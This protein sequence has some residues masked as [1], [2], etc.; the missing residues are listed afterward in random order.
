[1]K[2]FKS[3][4]K[5]FTSLRSS[6]VYGILL[7]GT[8]AGVTGLYLLV[9]LLMREN[10]TDTV[11]VNW[12]DLANGGSI[13]ILIAITMLGATVAGEVSTKMQA[14]A[15]LTQHHRSSWFTARLALSYLF[16]S[17]CL[18]VS[19]AISILLVAL[20]P[21]ASFVNEE[22]HF[23]L[24]IALTVCIY[25]L[26]AACIGVITGSKVAAIAIP[27]ALLMVIETLISLVVAFN[28]EVFGFLSLLSPLNR[29]NDI[30]NHAVGNTR[31]IGFHVLEN[32]Q[33]L[34][35]DFAVLGGWAALLLV[36]AYLV[37]NKRDAK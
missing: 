15:F 31:E 32:S 36:A 22:A 14:Q 27:L 5:K 9:S 2:A 37:N 25:S 19:I 4:L 28:A 17:L 30:T 7:I 1:M 24:Q 29:I 35:F 23:M 20:F 10:A 33:P 16:L 21:H 8:I 6:Y 12:A 34:W 26:M 13:F 18:L 3:E 11:T